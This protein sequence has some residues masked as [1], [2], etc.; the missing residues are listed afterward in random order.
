ML[1]TD[2]SCRKRYRKLFREKEH[3]A[4]GNL[5]PQEG[6]KRA[7]KGKDESLFFSFLISFKFKKSL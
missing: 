6:M 1:S 4:D 3:N 7:G 2:M 5:D